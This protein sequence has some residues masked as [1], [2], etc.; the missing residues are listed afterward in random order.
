MHHV[1]AAEVVH[2]PAP[3]RQPAGG[4]CPTGLLLSFLGTSHVV[5]HDELANHIAGEISGLARSTDRT[6]AVAESL[7]GG[8]ICAALAS[9]ESSS[10]WFRGALVAYA[11]EVKHAVLHVAEG[12]V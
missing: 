3:S 4:R 9:A 1:R 6:V 2:T 10:D 12:S 11:S 8:R 5:T 7:T